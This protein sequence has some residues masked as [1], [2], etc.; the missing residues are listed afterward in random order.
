M[1][2]RPQLKKVRPMG[3]TDTIILAIDP[4]VRRLGWCLGQGDRYIL[5]GCLDLMNG[6]KKVDI[7]T[8][9]GWLREW[10]EQVVVDYAPD[11]IAVEWPM[12]TVKN[13]EAFIKLGMALGV[14][15]SVAAQF[16]VAVIAVNPAQVKAT[17][18]HKNATWEAAM[19]VGKKRVGKD[20]ADAVGC[21]LAGLQ[22]I[23]ERALEGKGQSGD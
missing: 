9:M 15:G 5:S 20:E 12:A 13:I 17:G 19:L 21:W 16:D 4:A 7:W 10:M 6:H 22:I 23:L 14:I 11:V 2:E 3:L 18:Y 8:R 1:Q